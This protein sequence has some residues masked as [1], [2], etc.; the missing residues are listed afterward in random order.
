MQMSAYLIVIN[1]ELKPLQTLIMIHSARVQPGELCVERCVRQEAEQILPCI[2]AL[3]FFHKLL[4]P[5]DVV[6]NHFILVSNN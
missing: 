3:H 6:I 4:L 1:V 2:T 5:I